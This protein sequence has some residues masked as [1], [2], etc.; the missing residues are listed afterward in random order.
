MDN[1]L[2]IKSVPFYN[3]KISS[4]IWFK[5]LEIITL[6]NFARNKNSNI[7]FQNQ[8]V[9]ISKKKINL[10]HVKNNI[11]REENSYSRSLSTMVREIPFLNFFNNK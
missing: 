9:K 7:N 5:I 6:Q 11:K 10:Y 2:K 8:K 4:S 1:F 3:P